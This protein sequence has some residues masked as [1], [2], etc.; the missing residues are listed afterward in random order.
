MTPIRDPWSGLDLLPGASH[1]EI[2]KAYMRLRRALRTDSPALQSLEC[3]AARRDELAA[4]EEAF[5]SL[6]RNAAAP[7][8]AEPPAA[9]PWPAPR[10]ATRPARR[11]GPRRASVPLDR[12]VTGPTVRL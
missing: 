1:D 6:S 8:S 11:S 10:P 5:R 12:V 7:I 2:L 9:V 4:V 3:D